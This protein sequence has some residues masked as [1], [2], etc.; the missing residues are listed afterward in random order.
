M[1]QVLLVAG[2]VDDSHYRSS[3]EVL[4][5]DSSVWTLAT[6]LPRA[7]SGGR[8][9]A[10]DNSVYLT[11][12]VVY[13]NAMYGSIVYYIE[14]GFDISSDSERAEI[15]AWSN[16]KQEWVEKGKLQVARSYH[17]ATTIQLDGELMEYCG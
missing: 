9:V 15:L 17:G 5:G 12:K 8:S 1:L 16:E 7:V 4:T 2:G 10:L 6:P 3:T 13:C 11:G 14:G